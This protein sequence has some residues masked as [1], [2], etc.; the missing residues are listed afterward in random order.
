[1]FHD[2]MIELS[3]NWPAF[4]YIATTVAFSV[5]FFRQRRAETQLVR[6]LGEAIQESI[7]ARFDRLEFL[8]RHPNLTQDSNDAAI[9]EIFPDEISDNPDKRLKFI[10]E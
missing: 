10:V 2:I 9:S 8:V 4:V 1:M 3:D 6:R 5:F 7:R